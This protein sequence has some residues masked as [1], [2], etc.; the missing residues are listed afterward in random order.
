MLVK[1]NYYT[2]AIAHSDANLSCIDASPTI[3]FNQQGN[4]VLEDNFEASSE[5]SSKENCFHE[6]QEPASETI[7]SPTSSTPSYLSSFTSSPANIVS[8]LSGYFFT[9]KDQLTRNLMLTQT[10]TMLGILNYELRLLKFF[11]CA[12]INL[13]CKSMKSEMF[14]AWKYKVPQLF[15]QSDLVRLLMFSLAATALSAVME[16]D[17]SDRNNPAHSFGGNDWEF[18]EDVFKKDVVKQYQAEAN[19]EWCEEDNVHVQA[20]MYF[21]KTVSGTKRLVGT[22]LH[23]QLSPQDVSIAKELTV[24][25][26]LMFTFLGVQLH[27]LCKLI[28]FENQDEPDMISIAAGVRNTMRKCD[29]LV[30]QS[31]LRGILYSEEG[32]KCQSDDLNYSALLKNCNYPIIK[33]LFNHLCDYLGTDEISYQS[34]QTEQILTSHVEKLRVAL[35]ECLSSRLPT[36]LFIYLMDFTEE[37]KHLL[38]AKNPYALRILYVYSCLNFIA[39]FHVRVDKNIWQDYI[40]WYKEELE[41]QGWGWYEMDHCLFQLVIHNRFMVCMFENFEKL[42]PIKLNWGSHNEFAILDKYIM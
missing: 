30:R 38:Y 24:S 32:D 29:S 22:L 27:G 19:D 4:S 31:D 37:F 26:I 5:K 28:E 20:T 35:Y 11:D 40:V 34:S 39:R 10:T 15:L 41:Q 25:G 42:D 1:E 3:T 33:D 7:Y 17:V 9:E 18:D 36:S 13:Y 6:L 21:D 14:L 16:I 2:K 8:S 12:C 23:K